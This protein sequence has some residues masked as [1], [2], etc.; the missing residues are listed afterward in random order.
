[1]H[2]GFYIPIGSGLSLKLNSFTGTSSIDIQNQINTKSG[3]LYQQINTESLYIQK[4]INDFNFS[5]IQSTQI[6]KT[7]SVP[8]FELP[9]VVFSVLPVLLFKKYK[10][11]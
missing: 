5:T 8:G 4:I 7:N 11:I 3:S 10:K 6:I 2:S 1:M 9:I